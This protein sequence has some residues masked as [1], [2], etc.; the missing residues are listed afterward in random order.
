MEALDAPAIM[1]ATVAVAGCDARTCYPSSSPESERSRPPCTGPACSARSPSARTRSWRRSRSAVDLPSIRRRVA[2][3]WSAESC[4]RF[5]RATRI[6][7]STENV[8]LARHTEG[9]ELVRIG[10]PLRPEF[11]VWRYGDQFRRRR[12]RWIAAGAAGVA[13][14]LDT[15]VTIKLA[16]GGLIAGAGAGL[17]SAAAAGLALVTVQRLLNRQAHAAEFRRSDGTRCT[18]TRDHAAQFARIR[19]DDDEPAFASR[20][21]GDR[22]QVVPRSGRRTSPLLRL[23]WIGLIWTAGRVHWRARGSVWIQSGT[24]AGAAEPASR[25]SARVNRLNDG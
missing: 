3:G 9:L 18:L 10:E 4:E 5:F 17:L 22:S 20:S 2:S 12:R 8:G 16:T 15:S 24:T 1:C 14:N 11:A 25:C 6:R 23:R 7:T 13:G 19:A 21:T